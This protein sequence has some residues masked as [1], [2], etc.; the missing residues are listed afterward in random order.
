MHTRK[1]TRETIGYNNI[2]CWKIVINNYAKNE[3]KR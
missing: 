2:N 1:R 3:A